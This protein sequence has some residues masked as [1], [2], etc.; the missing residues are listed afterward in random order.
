MNE[1]SVTQLNNYIKSVFFAEEMLH[2]IAVV[3][4]IDGM[5]VRGNGV[6]FT[7][8][9]KDAA[10]PC[11]C[12]D[13]GRAKDIKNG[14][15]VTVRG[16]VD[17]WNK[18]GKIN[19][20]VYS[21]AK[22][23]VG[24]LFEQFKL[25]FE[26]LKAEGLFERKRGMPKEV[27]RIGVVSSRFGA[28]IHDIISVAWRR[29]PGVD[30]VLFPA[31]VQ[32][33]AAERE[34]ASGI[35]YFSANKTVDIVLIARGG[36]GSEDLSVFNS[37]R[38]ARAAAACPIPIVSAVGHETDFTLVDYTADLRAPTPSAAAEL[39]VPEYITNRA[40]IINL[41]KQL[42]RII[43]NKFDIIQNKIESYKSILFCGI[44]SISSKGKN[45]KSVADVNLD[46]NLLIKF[47]DGIIEAKV[48]KK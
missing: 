6:W 20:T 39:I 23:G 30:I 35:E 28:V 22:S 31:A 27:K 25:L 4:E 3:G 18:A 15:L 2:N 1:I 48:T 32:G 38:I 41:Y 26:K 40:K 46:D 47:G 43:L 5:S 17:Y 11:V 7:L 8:K 36:G 29:N 16:T 13:S 24:D 45:V 10:I 12:W 21:I 42:K 34:I 44:I 14:D 19:F 9:D 33:E 37:E